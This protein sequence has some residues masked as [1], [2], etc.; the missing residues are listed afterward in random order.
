MTSE[1]L[2]VVFV[3][4]FIWLSALKTELRYSVALKLGDGVLK[5]YN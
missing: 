1:D 3:P 5:N 2:Q 4:H